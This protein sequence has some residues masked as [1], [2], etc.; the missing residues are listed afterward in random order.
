[1]TN[2]RAQYFKD[3]FY[4]WKGLLC[5]SITKNCLQQFHEI[6]NLQLAR[7]EPPQQDMPADMQALLQ[8]S[9]SAYL[10][11]LRRSAKLAAI[12]KCL[13]HDNIVEAT[14]ELGIELPTISSEPV[15]HINSDRLRI[16]GGYYGFDA[17]QDWTSIQGSLDV[18]V[19]W[20]PLTKVTATNFPL[21]VIPRSHTNGLLDG[22]ITNNVYKINERCYQESEFIPVVAEPGDVV[23]MTG[24]T[25]HKTG[26][27]NCTGLRI[28]ASTRY[29][30]AAEPTFVEREYPCAYTR[31]VAREMMTPG[32]PEKKQIKKIFNKVI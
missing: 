14:S 26:V 27:E 20:V 31:S 13:T 28:S 11:A 30:N 32:F 24:W 3:G 19:V 17:H 5:P 16:P 23:F 25:V 1:M 10:A 21:M 2:K 4:L 9:Q 29:E 8:A 12:S 6:I 22:E 18:M 15:L 7:F